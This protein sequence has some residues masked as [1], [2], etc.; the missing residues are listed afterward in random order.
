MKLPILPPT[1]PWWDAWLSTAGLAGQTK[2]SIPIGKFRSQVVEGQTVISGKGVVLLT[3]AF[4]PAPCA[5]ARWCNPLI[6]NQ[7]FRKWIEHM[8]AGLQ[9]CERCSPVG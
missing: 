5:V 8:L 1:D 2:P 7:I 4:S 3:P 6:C 9:K